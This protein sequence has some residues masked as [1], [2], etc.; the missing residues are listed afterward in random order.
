MKHDKL[1]VKLSLHITLILFNK[2]SPPHSSQVMNGRDFHHQNYHHHL[3]FSDQGIGAQMNKEEM[4]GE[5][6][7]GTR[8][9]GKDW[10]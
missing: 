1:K 4:L 3:Q 5:H 9:K 7:C 8:V 6:F 2:F 10:G